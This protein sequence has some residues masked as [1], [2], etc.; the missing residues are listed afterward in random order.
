MGAKFPEFFYIGDIVCPLFLKISF[1]GCEILGS[2][3]FLEYLNVTPSTSL[4]SIGKSWSFCFLPSEN[5][6]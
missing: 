4:R 1:A 2:H 5:M 6:M 3:L